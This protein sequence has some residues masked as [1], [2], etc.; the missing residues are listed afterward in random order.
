MTSINL[1]PILPTCR[2]MSGHDCII[3]FTTRAG[4]KCQVGGGTR[5]PLIVDKQTYCMWS[6]LIKIDWTQSRMLLGDGG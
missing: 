5:R 1:L 3:N 2:G 4:T 6:N